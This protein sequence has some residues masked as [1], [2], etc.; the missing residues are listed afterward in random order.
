MELT[1]NPLFMYAVL[2]GLVTAMFFRVRQLESRLL[3]LD[4][5]VDAVLA[6]Q[7]PGDFLPGIE[8][9]LQAMHHGVVRATELATASARAVAQQAQRRREHVPIEEVSDTESGSE[10]SSGSESDA[11][12][13]ADAGADADADADAGAAE[14][15]TTAVEVTVEAPR[16][17]RSRRVRD[18][19]Q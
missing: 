1:Q 3:M 4:A 6:E 8:A 17:R 2:L 5:S 9:K 13:G 11:D 7:T 15:E 12:A 14:P 18:G 19:K 16:K 10:A